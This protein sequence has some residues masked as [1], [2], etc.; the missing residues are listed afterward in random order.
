MWY[1]PLPRQA[2]DYHPWRFRVVILRAYRGMMLAVSGVVATGSGI[3]YLWAR[4][5]AI[6]F[7]GTN[8][9][10]FLV[11]LAAIVFCI[12][13][14]IYEHPHHH[15]PFCIL[16]GGHAFIGYYLYIPLFI[17][18]ALALGVGTITP[19]RNRSSLVTI[20]PAISR[21]YILTSLFFW[22]CFI[23]LPA[24]A[25]TLAAATDRPAGYRHRS[26]TG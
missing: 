3:R 1:C 2:L 13:L 12:A 20:V 10:A 4:H 5:G 6:L 7:S 21:R 26:G 17:T 19:F 24:S 8:L 23:W 16:K 11:A 18:T 25:R 15:C 22:R 9:V 14:Y